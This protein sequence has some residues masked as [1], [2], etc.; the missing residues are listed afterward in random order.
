MCLCVYEKDIK[1][2]M[3][4]FFKIVSSMTGVEKKERQRER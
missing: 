2:A 1:M 4:T 3:H